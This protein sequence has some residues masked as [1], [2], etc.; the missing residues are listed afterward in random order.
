MGQTVV[1]FF[2]DVRDVQKAIQHL[3]S[4]GISNQHVDVSKGRHL[5]GTADPDGRNTNK[6]TDFFNKLFGHDSDDARLYSTIGQ[7]D[8]HILTVHAPSGDLAE[9]AADVLDDC[10]AMDVDEYK[11]NNSADRLRT[12]KNS[13]DRG[14]DRASTSFDNMAGRDKSLSARDDY[15]NSLTPE[16]IA[17]QVSDRTDF[18]DD[19]RVKYRQGA[20]NENSEYVDERNYPVDPNKRNRS[21]DDT[22]AQMHNPVEGSGQTNS[23]FGHIGSSHNDDFSRSVER[24]ESDQ[25]GYEER[26]SGFSGE[27]MTNDRISSPEDDQRVIDQRNTGQ[28][29]SDFNND[30]EAPGLENRIETP[31]EQLNRARRRSR[32]VNASVDRENRL[33]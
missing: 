11:N 7:E 12:Q 19:E 9:V 29:R 5:D 16:N 20:G 10:G 14:S 4:K 25:S 18:D 8:V 33:G 2:K 1:G 23:G 24:R 6:I 26:R 17:G 28:D 27:D 3:E 32:I 21:Q 30:E 13:S 15:A 31:Q 22:D